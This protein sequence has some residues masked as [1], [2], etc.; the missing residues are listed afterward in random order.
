MNKK[1]NAQNLQQDSNGGS[2]NAKTSNFLVFTKVVASITRRNTNNALA[3]AHALMSRS[4]P[5]RAS[6]V[7][8][9]FDVIII[10]I[11]LN[12]VGGTRSSVCMEG[13]GCH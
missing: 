3:A 9:A 4:A 10:V 2:D 8:K 5:N 7:E 1:I 11:L 12:T 6:C 13:C